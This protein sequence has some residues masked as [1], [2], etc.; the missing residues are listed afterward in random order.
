MSESKE[1]KG[2]SPEITDGEEVDNTETVDNSLD[3]FV[4]GLLER[5]ELLESELATTRKNERTHQG[6]VA[7]NL[8]L[9]NEIRRYTEQGTTVDRL[10][11]EN[12]QLRGQLQTQNNYI[13][14]MEEKLRDL[15]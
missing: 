10:T 13:Q 4:S 1:E 7:E 6:L 2:S 9:R 14:M 3:N 8:G 12:Q 11:A 15:Q 5:I